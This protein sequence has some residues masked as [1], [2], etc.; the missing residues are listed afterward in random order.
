MDETTMV[1]G[2][3]IRCMVKASLN[4]LTEEFTGEVSR[5][6]ESQGMAN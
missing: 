5:K 3:V 6:I 2:K 4:G 1:T